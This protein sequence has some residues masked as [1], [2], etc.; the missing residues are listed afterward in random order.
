M[1]KLA[2]WLF[3]YQK[4]IKI[5]KL[6]LSCLLITLSLNLSIT[7]KSYAQERK[8]LMLSLGIGVFTSPAGKRFESPQIGMGYAL[9]MSY[10][11]TTR[12]IISFN[13]TA[14]EHDYIEPTLRYLLPTNMIPPSSVGRFRV[15]SFMYKYRVINTERFSLALGTGFSFQTNTALSP[16]FYKRDGLGN[17][18]DYSWGVRSSGNTDLAFP[19]KGEFSFNIANRWA[20]GLEGGIF[21]MPTVYPWSGFHLLP[22]VSYIFR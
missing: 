9:D 5:M 4:H 13:H 17:L 21:L 20:I 22:R 2:K 6:L 7:I 12:H 8:D 19:F 18:I 14:G 3:Y 15:F 11:I 16:D 10:F 1:F